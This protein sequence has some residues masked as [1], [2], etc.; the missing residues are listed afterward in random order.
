MM[1]LLPT[2]VP[3]LP[4]PSFPIPG[5]PRPKSASRGAPATILLAG[6]ILTGCATGRAPSA[7]ETPASSDRGEITKSTRWTASSAEH[8]AAFHQA[9]LLATERLEE[10]A[11]GRKPGTWAVVVDADETAIDNV[12]YQVWLDRSGNHFEAETWREWVSRRQAPPLP[13]VVPF[14]QRIREL[15][16]TIAIVSNR[17]ERSREATEENF[18]RFGIPWDLMLLRTDERSK[19]GRWN[20]IEEGTA[21]P[22]WPPLEILMWIGDNI[23]DFPGGSQSDRVGD[24][25]AFREFGRRYIVLPNPTYGSW[26]QN[27]VSRDFEP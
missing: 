5:T 3:R 15:G 27:P 12:A 16:G 10:L 13:G 14:L 21:S 7:P 8:Q 1:T 17:S 2:P 22:E 19:E 18:R 24:A 4:R 20:A 26:E 23:R 25:E 6:L 9:Y 11:K